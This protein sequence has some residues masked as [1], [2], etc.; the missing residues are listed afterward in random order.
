LDALRQCLQPDEIV[1]D[2]DLLYA[3]SMDNLRFSRMPAAR[4]FPHDEDSVQ[5]VLQTANRLRVPVTVRG[6]GS[7]TT[8]ATTPL[9]DSWVLDFSRWQNIHIDAPARMA[10][11]QPGATVAAIDAAAAD[12]ELTY[13]VDP[14][15]HQYA[16]IGGTLATNAGGMRA[17]KYGVTRDFVLAL[18]GFLPTGD[19]VR[20]GA[21][22]RKFATGYNIRDL[23]VGS[24]GT[25]G[26][27][28]G[29]VLRLLPRPEARALAV[30]AFPSDRA[31]IS[32]VHQLLASTA[33]PSACEFIDQQ[34]LLAAHRF[35]ER[36]DAQTLKSLPACI[37]PSSHS[38]A[39][40]AILLIEVD[41]PAN[42]LLPQLRFCADQLQASQQ[43]MQIA[44]Q[45]IAI[46]ALWKI[47]KACSQAMFELGPR[48]LNEDVVI[49]LHAQLEFIDFIAQLHRS[50][51]IP[52]PTF[53]HVADGNFHVHLMFDDTNAAQLE[54]ANNALELLMQKVVD[55][56]G[57]ISGEHGVG[58]AKSAF[59]HLQ[60]SSA[61]RQLMGA[62]KQSFDPNRILNPDKIFFPLHPSALP[63]ESVHLPWDH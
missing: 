12:H 61:E 32:A 56:G 62:I 49:P 19:F 27:I 30:V 54:A 55:L 21:P 9:A 58:L 57:A 46:D 31:A 43:Q 37:F 8:G 59:L 6:A 36:T 63:R 44:T 40:P 47:R 2:P 39:P 28:T 33:C 20:W 11:V 15:S 34:S 35:W 13:P 51:S 7:A 5:A 16:T 24:E 10:Y 50:T 22:L 4:I 60:L 42:S 48:K 45:P 38:E 26:V 17:A 25:L 23:W 1:T 53:G 14:G 18:E 41:G 29:A 52:T 3:A